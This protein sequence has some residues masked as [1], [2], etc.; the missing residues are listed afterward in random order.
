MGVSLLSPICLYT[1]IFLIIC[2]IPRRSSKGAATS[3]CIAATTELDRH[4]ELKTPA[5][6]ANRNAQV[7]V[8]TRWTTH[9]PNPRAT[10]PTRQLPRVLGLI[11]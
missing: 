3:A 9:P 8:E 10:T 2:E 7:A 6:V 1:S 11:S 5:G 4:L